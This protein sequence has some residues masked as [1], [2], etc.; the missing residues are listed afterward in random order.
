MTCTE[1][2]IS[3]ELA[4][5]KHYQTNPRCFYKDGCKRTGSPDQTCSDIVRLDGCV[6]G[7]TIVVDINTDASFHRRNA[8]DGAMNKCPTR[9]GGAMNDCPYEPRNFTFRLSSDQKESDCDGQQNCRV[10]FHLRPGPD[11]GENELS[12]SGCSGLVYVIVNYTCTAGRVDSRFC[13]KKLSGKSKKKQSAWIAGS[14]SVNLF[15]LLKQGYMYSPINGKTVHV[16]AAI[17]F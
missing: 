8:S 14:Q 3:P 10:Y 2:A 12:T 13:F 16:F 6:T 11:G 15:Y 1:V 9:I 7:E 17:S 5:V 4:E